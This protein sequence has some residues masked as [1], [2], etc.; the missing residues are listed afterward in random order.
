[1]LSRS[2]IDTSVALA[3]QE[4]VRRGIRAEY[5]HSGGGIMVVRVQ[6][7]SNYEWVFGA[8][9]RRWGGDFSRLE[10]DA[11]GD[12]GHLFSVGDGPDVRLG[13]PALVAHW[14][15]SY[16]SL[17]PF[18]IDGTH[19]TQPYLDEPLMNDVDPWTYYGLP[20]PL[21][22]LIERDGDGPSP[23]TRCGC[24]FWA[25]RALASDFADP[26]RCTRCRQ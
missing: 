16:L 4:L 10:D 5:W 7:N 14:I 17:V 19:I 22:A 20:Y 23:C 12:A 24:R 11:Y 8:E 3:V 9:D 25:N 2:A 21:D 1:M 26:A 13:D 6:P 18:S 15:W